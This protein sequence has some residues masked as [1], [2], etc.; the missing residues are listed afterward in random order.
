MK[1]CGPRIEAFASGVPIIFSYKRGLLGHTKA[2]IHWKY[3][4]IIMAYLVELTGDITMYSTQ[5]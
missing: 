5:L 3:K 4:G 2:T 1:V